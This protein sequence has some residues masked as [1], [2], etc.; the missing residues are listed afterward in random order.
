MEFSRCFKSE[1]FAEGL[2]QGN[3][4]SAKEEERRKEREGGREEEGKRRRK[5]GGRKARKEGEEEEEGRKRGGG[6]KE[7]AE[8]LQYVM[9]K[10]QFSKL[11]AEVPVTF[12][13]VELPQKHHICKVKSL[14]KGDANSEVTVYYQMHMEE[15]CF[16]FLRTKETLGYHVYPTC[17][18]TS[19][20]LGFSVTVETQATKFNSELVE[21]KIEEFLASFGE[22]LN[23]L[24]EEAFNTQVTALVKLK[25]CEDTHLGEEVDRNWSEVLT[26]QYVFDRLLKEIAALKQMTK[27]ELV[28]WFQ[29]HRGSTSRKLSVHVVGF[30]VE[31]QDAEG[32]AE[33]RKGDESGDD[34]ESGSTYGEV[35]RLFYL[36]PS[37]RIPGANPIMDIPTFTKDLPLF[38]YHKILE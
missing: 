18:N 21:L 36:P 4:T 9:D 25:E 38:P 6:R 37:E 29:E 33:R 16:D 10:L 12:R 30:G 19:G 5:R 15:P 22:K 11:P 8:F 24:T 35:S 3:F 32:G 14:N 31:E 7:S 1:M 28:S 27:E 20:V 2:V 23:A 13:V 34:E 26:Q 17:R